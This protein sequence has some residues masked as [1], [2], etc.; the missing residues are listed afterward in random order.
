ML[1][2]QLKI[3]LLKR[4]L[5]MVF[6]L[7]LNI[8]GDGVFH[9]RADRERTVTVL[10]CKIR[11]RS[12]LLSDVFA[13]VRF[14]LSNE[15]CDR[16]L[17]RYAYQQVDVVIEAADFKCESIQVLARTCH[18]SE[19]LVA[20]TIVKQSLATFGAEDDV[21]EKFLVSRHA[22]PHILVCVAPSGLERRL[23]PQPGPD[24]PGKGCF[25]PPGLP[26]KAR[27]AGQIGVE[28]LSGLPRARHDVPA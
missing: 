8:T 1:L 20:E 22:L 17:C 13:G 12:T 16:D 9:R 6:H 11:R 26:R 24:G 27:S 5:T 7:V 23:Y 2:Q 21:I 3:L 14:Y 28:S 4:P 19:N 10:P 18:V 25:S 15:V